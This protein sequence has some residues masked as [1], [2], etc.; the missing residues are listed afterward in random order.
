MDVPAGTLTG[1]LDLVAFE[2][3]IAHEDAREGRYRRPAAVVMLE[4]VGLDRLIDRLGAAAGSRVD[5]ASADT[6]SRLARRADYV[7]RLGP[8][9]YAVLMPETDEILAINYV[10][11]VRLAC[12]LWLEAGEVAMRLAIGWA[13]TTGDVSLPAVMRT[14][15]D[16]MRAEQ[17]RYARLRTDAA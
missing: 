7:A 4:L 8:G 12:E 5:G 1:L 11:R 3:V 10:E 2:E 13:S 6:V 16:R 17:R 9:S 15:S 14:A